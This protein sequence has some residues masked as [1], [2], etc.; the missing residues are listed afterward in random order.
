M[1]DPDALCDDLERLT[2]E[3]PSD[4]HA[5]RGWEEIAAELTAH[6]SVLVV[7]NTRRDCR[8]LHRLMPNGTIH[9]SAAM[10]GEHR[11]QIIDVILE[12]VRKK[13]STRVISTQLVE[14]G[15]DIDFPVVYRAVSGLGSIA[16]AAR[17]CNREDTAKRGK[18][19]LFV[20]PKR[21]PPGTLRRAEQTTISLMNGSDVDPIAR[22]CFTRYF[23][24]FYVKADSL[25]KHGINDLL[26]RDVREL[27]I[28]FRTAAEKFQL[29]DDVES[30][31]LL[32]WYGE[33]QAAT[34]ER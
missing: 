11:G 25:D 14:A 18:V 3:M 31:A 32:V 27:K 28:Q 23:E 34:I 22:E 8:E 7:V 24:H 30:R 26:T 29:I 21:S 19:V 12:R 15:M 9:L 4:F 6:E 33:S 13:I 20:S 16:Q 17:R 2:V 10:C 1:A 5:R